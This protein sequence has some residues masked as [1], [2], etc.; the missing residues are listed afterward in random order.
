M[1]RYLPG[2]RSTSAGAGAAARTGA[3]SLSGL[4]TDIVLTSRPTGTP[5]RSPLIVGERGR[6][7]LGRTTRYR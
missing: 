7:D 6:R 3:I 1:L 4:R 2:I 5:D